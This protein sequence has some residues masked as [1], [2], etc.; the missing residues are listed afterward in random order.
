MQF[1]L[2]LGREC[3]VIARCGSKGTEYELQAVVVHRGD[4]KKGHYIT[5]LKP[6][7]GPHW[8]LFDDDI[9]KWVQEKEVL[10]Q[11]AT[12]LVYTRPDGVVETETIIIPDDGQEDRSP[13]EMGDPGLVTTTTGNNTPGK[14]ARESADTRQSS[15]PSNMMETGDHSLYRELLER[16]F[17]DPATEESDLEKVM[18]GP[19]NKDQQLQEE[20][21]Q[22]QETRVFQDH[23]Q[24][25][26]LREEEVEVFGN[27]LFLSI[28]RHVAKE[29]D[30][31]SSE[32]PE[33]PESRYKK[34]ARMVRNLALDHMLGHRSSFESSFG[35]KSSTLM[36][37]DQM[38]ADNG[39]DSVPEEV[40]AAEMERDALDSA[41]DLD[42]DSYCGR[43]RSETAQGDELTIRAAA[44][45]LQINI[46]VLKLNFTTTTIMALTYP[47]TPPTPWRTQVP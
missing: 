30:M 5:F 36:G 29:S 4:S 25:H 35:K 24:E 9:V 17:Q 47:G 21:K 18:P 15:A 11:E 8:A 26:G 3:Q 31:Y 44:W 40:Q 6:A 22:R 12:I 2:K 13:R 1:P 32:T 34:T 38:A 43:M 37:N 23:L 14:A 27:C 45:A 10:D 20:A 41:L 19:S 46:R 39:T 28:A 16:A 42:L 33:D 7:G